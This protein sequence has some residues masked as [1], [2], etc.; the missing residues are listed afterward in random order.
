MAGQRAPVTSTMRRGWSATPRCS[1]RWLA[2]VRGSAPTV[3][4]R[5]A[6][7]AGRGR[8]LLARGVPT[9]RKQPSR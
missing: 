4:C 2:G 9:Y 7:A 1:R 6:L 5:C 8:P 3:W